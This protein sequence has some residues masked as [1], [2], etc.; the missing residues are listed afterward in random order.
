MES[1][2]K[3]I[4]KTPKTTFPYAFGPNVLRDKPNRSS[5]IARFGIMYHYS[6]RLNKKFAHLLETTF[7][8][9][10]LNNRKVLFLYN[11]LLNI[12]SF[13]LVVQ[14]YLSMDSDVLLSLPIQFFP[15]GIINSIN[16]LKCQC[17]FQN[18]SG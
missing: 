5:K 4:N 11:H 14:L 12:I 15:D 13:V 3:Q 10:V 8:Q 18:T 16:R 17:D 1:D 6:Q 9:L 2:N 7:C